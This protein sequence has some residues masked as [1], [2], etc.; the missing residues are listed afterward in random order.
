M[1]IGMTYEQYWYDDPLMVRA[2][3]K[4]HE[5]RRKMVDEEAWMSGLYV[6]GA[7]NA[8]VGNMFRKPGTTPAEYPPEPYFTKKE[9]EKREKTEEEKKRESLAALAWMS[10]FVQAGKNWEK[11]KEAKR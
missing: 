7:L 8:T 11:N 3:Y 9:R 10:S 5:L 2:F 4:A 6:L 1:A